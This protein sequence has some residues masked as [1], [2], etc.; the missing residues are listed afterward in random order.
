MTDRA[1]I[2]ALR[3]FWA[4]PDLKGES[5]PV[6]CPNGPD[7]ETGEWPCDPKGYFGVWE[8][9]TCGYM[10]GAAPV[11]L[12]AANEPPAPKEER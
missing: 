7:P 1:L 4:E 5:K 9:Q 10:A 8:C 3:D 2:A 12:S 6:G 11:R